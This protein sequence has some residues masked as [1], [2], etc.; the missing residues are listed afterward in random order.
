[1]ILKIENLSKHFNGIHALDDVSFHI[2]ENSISS[3]IGPNGAGKTT[4]FNIVTGFC[5][6]DSGHIIFDGVPLDEIAPY[7]MLSRNGGIARTFQEVRLFNQ[8]SVL[9]NV[10]AGMHTQVGENLWSAIFRRKTMRKEEHLRRDR[11]R[12]LLRY[13]GISNKENVLAADLSYGQKKLLE[14]CRALATG[15]KFLLLDEPTAGIHPDMIEKVAILIRR[16]RDELDKTILFIEHNIDVV[17][18]LSEKIIVLDH[19]T[20]IAE[21]KP[22]D[23]Q[24]DSLVLEAYLKG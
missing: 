5:K 19:G 15:A 20:K 18:G 7:Q 24:Q 10:L 6:P 14:L 22:R 8:M 11:A 9:D 2:E 16:L 21:G 17:M 13:V 23:I 4:F 12:E 3:L 1:M